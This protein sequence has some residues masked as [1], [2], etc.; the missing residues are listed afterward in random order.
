MSACSQPR[1]TLLEAL[2]KGLTGEI[3]NGQRD[4]QFGVAYAW[5]IHPRTHTLEAYA[6]D[7]RAWRDIGRFAGG[8]P[9]ASASIL[10]PTKPVRRPPRVPNRPT[11]QSSASAAWPPFKTS[12]TTH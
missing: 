5:L 4:A 10:T 3:L 12:P 2:P 6:L 11:H 7:G 1:P 9:T 8:A